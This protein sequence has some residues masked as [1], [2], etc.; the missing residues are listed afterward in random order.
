M[1]NNA[2]LNTVHNNKIIINQSW[3]KQKICKGQ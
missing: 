1:H 2:N 3:N